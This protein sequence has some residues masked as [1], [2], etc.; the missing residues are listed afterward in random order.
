MKQ[1]RFKINGNQYNVD[2][3]SVEGK[4]NLLAGN[5]FCAYRKGASD[6]KIIFPEFCPFVLIHSIIWIRKNS[7]F[8]KSLHGGAGHIHVI[9]GVL[10]ADGYLKIVF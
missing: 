5:L 7:F 4:K 3:N 10:A 6:V 1:Y 2:I 9:P 8:A